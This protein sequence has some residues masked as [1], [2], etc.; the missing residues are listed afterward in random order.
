MSHNTLLAEYIWLD[1][2]TPTQRLRSKTRVLQADDAASITPES[3]P[4]WSY[5]GSSTNQA[6]GSASDLLL[7]P[8]RVVMDP[9]RGGVNILVLC[10][11]LGEDGLPHA[12]NQ[13]A[14]LRRLLAEGGAEY[15]PIV[16]FE[17][18]YTLFRHGRP[19]GFPEEGF[20]APQGPYYCGVGAEAAFGRALVEA[21]AQACLDAGLLLYGTNAEVMP[22]QWEFQMGYRGF[23]GE[24]GDPL[25][26]SDHLWLAR[27]PARPPGRGPWGRRELRQQAHGRRLERRR[28]PHELLDQADA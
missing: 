2:A 23:A 15:E 5:D 24:G 14:E 9:I 4:V 7:Q 18:E 19:L 17:Q 27:V 20:P 21:H 8:V 12:T 26:V 13:R 10:E 16:G 6:D 3:L 22:G 11:V 28:G 25:V 1:G